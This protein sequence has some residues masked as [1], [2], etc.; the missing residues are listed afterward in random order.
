MNRVVAGVGAAQGQDAVHAGASG[1]GC[2]RVEGRGGEREVPRTVV[3]DR[4]AARTNGGRAE[5]ERAVAGVADAGVVERG[6]VAAIAQLHTAA[7][8]SST[9]RRGSAEVGDGVDIDR[10]GVDVEHA[11]KGIE[12]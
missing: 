7:G 11:R 10:A 4:A 1:V 5:L 12:A 8:N 3:L 9:H 2:L 6:A